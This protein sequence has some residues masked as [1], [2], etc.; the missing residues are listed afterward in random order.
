MSVISEGRRVRRLRP[1]DAENMLHF[2]FLATVNSAT[3]RVDAVQHLR[4]ACA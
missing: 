4:E 2:T 3:F 1:D